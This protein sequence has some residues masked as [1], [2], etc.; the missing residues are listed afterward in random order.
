MVLALYGQPSY[1]DEL[2]DLMV[3]AHLRCVRLS[4]Y[5]ARS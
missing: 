3:A 4:T 5:I 2:R 1:V